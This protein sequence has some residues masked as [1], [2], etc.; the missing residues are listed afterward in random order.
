MRLHLFAIASLTL[1]LASCADKINT[2]DP[3]YGPN[4][5][6]VYSEVDWNIQDEN[7]S[8]IKIVDSTGRLV[9]DMGLGLV[10]GT[11]SNKIVY[12]LMGKDRLDGQGDI[13]VSN[14]DGSNARKVASMREP[15]QEFN[16]FPVISANGEMV[17]YSTRDSGAFQ[18]YKK[19]L[20]VVRSDGSS[21]IVITEHLARETNY[22][23]SPDGSRIAFY[24]DDEVGSTVLPGDLVV[25]RT[26]GTGS[27]S[28][29]T[30]VTAD[31]DFRSSIQWNAEGTK[32][33]ISLEDANGEPHINIVNADGSGVTKLGI[34]IY[35]TWSPDG[36]LIAWSGV[37]QDPSH[38]AD[39]M[40]S[41]DM[42][43][44]VVYLT[45]T[46]EVETHPQFSPDGKKLLCTL[47]L[48][49][50]QESPGKLK[51]ID[52]ESKASKVI[53]EPIFLGY[54]IR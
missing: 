22:S 3:V 33:L 7:F 18:E 40:Y 14:A 45:S 6:L 50:A 54:W 9:K 48:D 28:L 13:Y 32:L 10:G 15:G 53:A 29:I 47:W 26:D 11:G 31:H 19:V 30:D 16:G 36:K 20:H 52:I 23:L 42:G 17:A 38:R 12:A 5:N 46:A 2:P 25:A 1:G 8:R 4:G 51:V 44:T 41:E 21:H 37:A 34:G 49:D 35:P 39:I 27:T 24:T 43:L